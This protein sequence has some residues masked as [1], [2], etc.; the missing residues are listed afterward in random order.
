MATTDYDGDGD[1]AE[2]V[3]GEIGTMMDALYAAIQAYAADTA[4]APIQYSATSYP[5]FFADPNAN[6]K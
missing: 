6:G 1:A 5:Y 2:G 4:G 3:A